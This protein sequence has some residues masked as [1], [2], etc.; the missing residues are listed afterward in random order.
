VAVVDYRTRIGDKLCTGIV[1]QQCFEQYSVPRSLVLHE[2]RNARFVARGGEQVISR[3]GTQAYVIDRM[4]FVSL[5]AERAREAGASYLTGCTVAG[6]TRHDGYV[7]VRARRGG[8]EQVLEARCVVVASGTGTKLAEMAG[9]NPARELAFASQS[10]ISAPGL[11]EVH[12]LLPGVLP[13]GYFGWIV[14]QGGG[15]A[16]LGLLGRQRDEGAL[17]MAAQYAASV[18]F[19]QPGPFNWR[20]WPVPVAPA[21][22][23]SAERAVLVGDAAGQVKPTSGGGIYY[24]LLSADIAADTLGRALTDDDLSAASL[25]EYDLAW[26]AVLQKELRVGCFARSIFERLDGP[27]LL[28][29]LSAAEASGLLNGR[30]SFDWHSEIITRVFSSRLFDASTAS[31]RAVSRFLSRVR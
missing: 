31:L 3:K 4:A 9:L 27:A 5:L 26:K 6:V 30:G 15:A 10:V 20:H 25:H 17:H 2:A 16:L 24:A 1:G 11:E 21:A 13:R 23:T 12:V 22:A 19:G 29:L 28:R 14:P 8:V 18:G 7:E